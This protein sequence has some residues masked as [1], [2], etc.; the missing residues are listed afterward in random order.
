[1]K[2]PFQWCLVV[3]GLLAASTSAAMAQSD[4]EE[5]SED[6]CSP[7]KLTKPFSDTEP[8]SGFR[9]TAD[10]L[11]W[12]RTT[13]TTG[14]PVIGGPESFTLGGLSNGFVG[15]YRLGG[16]WLIDPNYEVEGVWTTFSDW[17][18]SNGGI[19][20]R[21]ISFNNGQGNTLVDPSGN[22]NFINTGTF[23]R[24]VFDAAM[25]PLANPAI[26]NYAFL[27]G[28]STYTLYSSSSLHDTQVNFKTRRTSGRRFAFG[29]GYRNVGFDE[30][31]TAVVSGTFGTNDIPAG[32][33]THTILTDQALTKHGLTLLS[34]AADG[35]TNTPANPMS[36]SM[37]WNGTASNQMNG[38]QGTTDATL[39]QRGPFALEGVVRKG[40]FYNRISGSARE[41]YTASGSD[42]S[43]YGRSFTDNRDVVSF[44]G[45]AGLNGVYSFNDFVRFRAGYEV[46]LL[47]NMAVAG[48]QQNGISYNSLGNAS[49]SVQGGSNIFFHG[50]RAGLEVVW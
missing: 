10:V 45:N 16:A 39:L 34:G 5:S 23:F 19:L 7:Y 11:I 46:M 27:N 47:T 3:I 48:N 24:P 49:Y 41:V 12:T 4:D 44:V 42:N 26:L 25:D 15:G 22:A 17:T 40:I 1:M 8:D 28:N 6:N 29:V 38:I 43:V 50:A 35:W 32:G 37:L 18:A 30:S 2:S 9:F 14:T 21:A 36:L 33:T 20:S 31:T 13:S